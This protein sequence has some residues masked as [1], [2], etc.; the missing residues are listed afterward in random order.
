M[1]GEE[2]NTQKTSGNPT[3][4]ICKSCGK[5]SQPPNG[6]EKLFEYLG[7]HTISS[8]FLVMGIVFG[9]FF[10]IA[11]PTDMREM[12]LVP[13]VMFGGA[14][15]VTFYFEPKSAKQK[16]PHCRCKNMLVPLNSPEGQKVKAEIEERR[17]AQKRLAEEK[18]I[19]QEQEDKEWINDPKTARLVEACN[20]ELP[21]LYQ[22]LQVLQTKR[23]AELTARQSD[24]DFFDR[25]NSNGRSLLMSVGSLATTISEGA[26][27]MKIKKEIKEI[28]ARISEKEGIIAR[29]S[30]L[31][32]KYQLPSVEAVCERSGETGQESTSF[33]TECG[34]PRN[35][36]EKFCGKC[37]HKF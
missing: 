15:L 10:L 14:S 7:L 21:L 12:V 3:D 6:I 27:E 29:Y 9:I 37:G 25:R 18:R 1:N 2:K 28:E 22:K 16:C 23:T 5:V 31:R 8:L 34:N 20:R 17:L 32:E 36:G 24:R 11:T 4:L 13:L 30:Q 26:S 33:C 35:N 19:E